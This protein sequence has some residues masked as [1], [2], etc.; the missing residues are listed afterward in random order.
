[1]GVKIVT[2]ADFLAARERLDMSQQQ[3][4][5]MLACS[6]RTLRYWEETKPSKLA[7]RVMEW[8]INSGFRPPEYK[9]RAVVGRRSATRK[10]QE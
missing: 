9:T 4:A 5:I 1:M 8:I 2:A 3:C 7:C 10:D 6:D